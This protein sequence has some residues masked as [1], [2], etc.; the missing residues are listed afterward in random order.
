MEARKAVRNFVTVIEDSRRWADITY[1]DDDIVVSTPPKCGTTWTQGIISS[2]LW[3]AGDAPGTLS[4][5]SPWPDVRNRPIEEIALSLKNQHHRRFIKTH[6]PADCIPL[7][8]RVLYVTVH[9]SPADALVSW[10]NHRATMHPE[11]MEAFNALSEPDGIAPRLLRFDG[12]YDVLLQEW[13]IDCSPATHLASW[14]PLRGEPN[15]LM[16]HYADLVDDL[17]GQMRRIAGFLNI[18]VSDDLW[19]AAVA[20]CELDAMREEAR[21]TGALE[22]GFKGGPDAF[23]NKGGN[24]RGREILNDDQIDRIDRH[25]AKHLNSNALAWLYHESRE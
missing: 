22:R 23:F 17:S 9:R 18:D 11:I 15:V 8:P 10:G 6:S 13:L 7:D 12:D 20:R 19:P 25:C 14:W 4:E 21:S 5:R 16:L 24:G 2:L 3:P 1:R